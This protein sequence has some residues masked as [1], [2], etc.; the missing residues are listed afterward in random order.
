MSR[1]VRGLDVQ[2]SIYCLHI[3]CQILWPYP[4]S[5]L[6]VFPSNQVQPSLFHI[7]LAFHRPH[8][9]F[10]EFFQGLLLWAAVLATVPDNCF[11][12]R[13]MLQLNCD[14]KCGWGHQ[15]NLKCHLEYCSMVISQ[16]VWIGQVVQLVSLYIHIMLLFCC[17]IF[18]FHENC[19]IN[20]QEQCLD[21]FG[22][23][24]IG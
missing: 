2:H 19:L 14:H 24:D 15:A 7:D 17:L 5:F 21:Y 23:C 13:C 18:E 1:G 10:L 16:H 3:H 8:Y 12:S 11:W 4:W 22:G 9:K 20:I 6:P